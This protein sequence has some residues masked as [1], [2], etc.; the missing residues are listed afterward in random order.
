MN[1][2]CIVTNDFL[3]LALIQ[4]HVAALMEDYIE[5]DLNNHG[6]HY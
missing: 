5:R 3:H 1:V 2:V 6:R 4:G